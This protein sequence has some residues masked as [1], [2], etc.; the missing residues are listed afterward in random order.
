ME[1]RRGSRLEFVWY[2]ICQCVKQVGFEKQQKKRVSGELQSV[3]QFPAFARPWL[4]TIYLII[5]LKVISKVLFFNIPNSE[6]YKLISAAVDLF[7]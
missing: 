5:F 6:E 4:K 3:V 7:D 1:E 2:S